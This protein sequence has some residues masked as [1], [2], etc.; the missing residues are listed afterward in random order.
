VE[1]TWL[2]YSCF[3]LKG[4]RA[5]VITDPYPPE[6]GYVMGKQSARIVTVSHQHPDHSYT[7]GISG[8]LRVIHGPGEYEISDI[9]IQGITSFHDAE[10]GKVRGK[11][12]IYLLEIDG[13]S[14]CHL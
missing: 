10:E 11:N 4:S 1:I 9:L 14:I 5:V 7:G 13:V 8:D 3:R 2:G 12:T 6:L